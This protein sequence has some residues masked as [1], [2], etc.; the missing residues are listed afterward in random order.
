[1]D[2]LTKYIRI[3]IYKYSVS[4]ILSKIRKNIHPC[5]IIKHIA[6]QINAF[7]VIH[8][9]QLLSVILI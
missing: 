8:L 9:Q 7:N 3:N 2:M 1:M 6:F 5:D 4:A